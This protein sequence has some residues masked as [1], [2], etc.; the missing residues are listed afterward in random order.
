MKRDATKR[1]R[2]SRVALVGLPGA[3]KST[4]GVLLAA[5]LGWAFA[6]SDAEVERRAG[7]DIAAIFRERGEAA[8]R[9]LER[10]VV[11]RI[12]ERQRIVIATGGGWIAQPGTIDSLP[13][14]A[15]LV[16]LQV[17]PAEAA[18]RLEEGSAE[19]P[20]LVGGDVAT[21]IAEL[22]GERLL[23]YSAANIVVDTN[24]RSPEAIAAD[25]AARLES[26][27]GIDGQAD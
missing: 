6:D 11:R 14:D 19:R 27:Y 16:W 21:R 15:T 25:I 23:S 17:A 3:G 7:L 20:L 9:Q 13:P 24:G 2:L 10:E 22:E 8:F 1:V 4:I 26:E 18:L 5:R 12:L